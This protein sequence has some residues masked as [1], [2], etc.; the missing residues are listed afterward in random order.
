MENVWVFPLRQAC[1]FG[2]ENKDFA[3]NITY[4]FFVTTNYYGR[5][6]RP[7]WIDH[8]PLGFSLQLRQNQVKLGFFHGQN[9]DFGRK[10][11]YRQR[12]FKNYAWWSVLAELLIELL[13]VRQLKEIG[14]LE[15]DFAW[16]TFTEVHD[17]VLKNKT[18]A[19]RGILIV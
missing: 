18:D 4:F 3:E 11:R 16:I 7:A 12:S 8:G 6:E 2:C 13:Y 14:G 1:K 19:E 17:E 10:A 5:D 9:A 15:E